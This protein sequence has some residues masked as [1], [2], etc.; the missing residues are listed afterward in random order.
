LLKLRR[1]KFAWWG[2]YWIGGFDKIRYIVA[3]GFSEVLA[4]LP[5]L[6][7]AERELLMRR[8][9]E[10]DEPELSAE[11]VSLRENR[12]AEHHR[13][14]QSAVRHEEMKARL[15]SRIAGA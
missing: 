7:L 3:M 6:T 15:R 10:L 9:L 14:R 8:A 11:D 5:K 13:N 4:E 2:R 1:D 12:L